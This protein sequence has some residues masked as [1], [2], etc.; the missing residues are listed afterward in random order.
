MALL[1]GRKVVVIGGSS[2]L[3]FAVAKGALAEGAMVVIGSSD[4]GKVAAAV[5]RLG[6]ATGDAINVRDEADVAAFFARVGGFD[7]LAFTAG[8]WA[9]GAG[10]VRELDLAAAAG[11]FEVRFWGALAVIKHALPQLA[12]DG[13]I[14]LTS[15]TL[16]HRPAKGMPL[17]T[18]M[19]GAGEHLVLG[20]A[21]D[22]APVRV[23]GVCSGAAATEMWDRYPPEIRDA[24]FKRMTEKLPIPRMGA[25][26]ELAGTYLHLMRA[27]YPTGQIL[28]VDGGQTLV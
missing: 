11:M 16:A 26:D 21:V 20:L 24:Q 22:L 5:S 27:T 2:G 4:A 6:S 10:S 15:G 8:D 13:S 28:R 12:A 9:L 7:H 3:G 14:T 19:A 1:A 23:N 25:P 17:A 18:A